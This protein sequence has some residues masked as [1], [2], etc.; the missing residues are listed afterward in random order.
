M[1]IGYKLSLVM[2]LIGMIGMSLLTTLMHF[3]YMTTNNHLLHERLNVAGR[4]IV[5]ILENGLRMGI[6]LASLKEI[7]NQIQNLQKNDAT[8]DDIVI[9]HV[10]KDQLSP[11]F[12]NTNKTLQQGDMDTFIRAMRGSK[13]AEWSGRLE[14]GKS[15]FGVLL[16]DAA[17][18]ERAVFILTYDSQ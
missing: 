10:D 9:Y 4:G 3:R 17:H 1:K 16:K 13:T 15:F 12:C 5:R 11:L 6:D 2:V 18:T 8:I 7:D 14:N